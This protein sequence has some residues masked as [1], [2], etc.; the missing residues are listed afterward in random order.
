MRANLIDHVGD[1]AAD[2]LWPLRVVM[3]YN[4]SGSDLAA[5]DV[6]QVDRGVTTFG[7]GRAIKKQATAT[8][9][10]CLGGALRAIPNGT[11]GEVVVEGQQD[12]V[13]MVTGVTAGQQLFACNAV[14]GAA[15]QLVPGAAGDIVEVDYPMA[16]VCT[17]AEASN[18]G[19]V[20]WT[21]PQKVSS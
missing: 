4:G 10:D 1:V 5:G 19:S 6:V 7:Q 11:W 3:R 18:L 21:N 17:T 14:T 2:N 20:R 9:Q 8:P 16:G 13:A 12:S 15:G